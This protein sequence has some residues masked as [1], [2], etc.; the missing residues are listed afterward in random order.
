MLQEEN[1]ALFMKLS[2]CVS[3][4]VLQCAAVCC[5]GLQCAAVCS[6]VL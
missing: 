2:V 5:G 1:D 6:G 4:S 3:C